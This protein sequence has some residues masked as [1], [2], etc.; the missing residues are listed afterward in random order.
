[1]DNEIVRSP[2]CRYNFSLEGE[3]AMAEKE[4]AKNSKRSYSTL[5]LIPLYIGIIVILYTNFNTLSSMKDSIRELKGLDSERIHRTLDSL[6]GTQIQMR[7]DRLVTEV[8]SLL[9]KYYY[10]NLVIETEFIP[11]DIITLINNKIRELDRMLVDENKIG[12]IETPDYFYVLGIYYAGNVSRKVSDVNNAILN[13]EK[14]KTLRP[15][16]SRVLTNLGLCYE[17][18]FGDYSKAIGFYENALKY[19]PAYCRAHYNKALALWSNNN[20]EE[21]IKTITTLVK[22]I[23]NCPEANFAMSLI[24]YQQGEIEEAIS[25]LERAVE[26]EFDDI[27]W[28]VITTFYDKKFKASEAYTNAINSIY[29]FLFIPDNKR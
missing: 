5:V 1:M 11:G 8:K 12:A 23:P 28:M 21:A 17:I 9:E 3:G 10:P 24:K 6:E 4:K 22:N 29:D 27:S 26:L 13:F 7:F 2:W 20:H 18:G 16:D 25:C 19:E 14:Y 15:Y